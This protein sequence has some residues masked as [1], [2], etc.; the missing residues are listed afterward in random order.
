M[1]IF[2]LFF[3]ISSEEGLFVH[4]RYIFERNIKRPFQLQWT[5][6]NRYLAQLFLLH[7]AQFIW[8]CIQRTIFF[9]GNANLNDRIWPKLYDTDKKEGSYV[10]TLLIYTIWYE[11]SK[12]FDKFVV[13]KKLV[14]WNHYYLKFA[15][16][17]I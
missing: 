12:Y 8:E 7:R 2:F 6:A 10:E 13:T 4:G 15:L 11:L 3:F 1:R 16:T 9:C 14:F 17:A 5:A